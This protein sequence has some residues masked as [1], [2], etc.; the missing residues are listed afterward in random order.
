[1]ATH[2]TKICPR[3][4]GRRFPSEV[5]GL[6]SGVLQRM[7]TQLDEADPDLGL[8]T[9]GKA[10]LRAALARAKKA[11]MKTSQVILALIILPCSPGRLGP[12]PR[13]CVHLPRPA[14]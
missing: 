3:C 6:V 5:Q 2:R 1:M 13:D 8:K 4:G 10:P 7:L 11:I 14:Q 12:R 9:A